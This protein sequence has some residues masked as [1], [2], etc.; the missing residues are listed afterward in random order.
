[1]GSYT[2]LIS[3]TEFGKQDLRDNVVIKVF[4]FGFDLQ[5]S[6]SSTRVAT[7]HQCNQKIKNWKKLLHSSV[8]HSQIGNLVT[9]S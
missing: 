5:Q 1:M 8:K 9:P 7:E 2:M 3:Y 6:E 4:T